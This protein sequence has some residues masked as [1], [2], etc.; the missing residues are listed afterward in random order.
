MARVEIMKAH[1]KITVDLCHPY[2]VGG[3]EEHPALQ[4]MG[5]VESGWVELEMDDS[6]QRPEGVAIP[7][8]AGFNRIHVKANW[9]Y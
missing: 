4:L 7:R 5:H 2:G 1:P 3:G 9:L 8:G 6:H